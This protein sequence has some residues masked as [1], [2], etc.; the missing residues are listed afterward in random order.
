MSAPH[1]CAAGVRKYQNVLR[2]V[3]DRQRNTEEGASQKRGRGTYR[4]EMRIERNI[5]CGFVRAAAGVAAKGCAGSISA[6]VVLLLSL[7]VR[8]EVNGGGACVIDV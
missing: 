3:S 1:S 7:V 4:L 5:G 2:A 8:I 6:T